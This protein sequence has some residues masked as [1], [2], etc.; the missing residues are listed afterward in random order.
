MTV[1]SWAR[2]TQAEYTGRESAGA[3]PRTQTRE[4]APMRKAWRS[5]SIRVGVSLALVSPPTF[6]ALAGPATRGEGELRP[7][8][9]NPTAG[10]WPTW[11]IQSGSQFRL[12][13]PAD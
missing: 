11:A 7:A 13:P 8:Q 2:H 1:C 12:P 10:S 3:A 9:S 6:P 4:V 5:L